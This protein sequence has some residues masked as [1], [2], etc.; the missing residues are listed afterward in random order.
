[1]YGVVH[2]GAIKSLAIA[3]SVF[4]SALGPVIMGTPI[5]RGVFV[6]SVCLLFGAYTLL[7]LLL[8]LAAIGTPHVR[9]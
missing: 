6:E 7:A 5:D 9:P 4:A 2:L 1:M 3:L 8:V